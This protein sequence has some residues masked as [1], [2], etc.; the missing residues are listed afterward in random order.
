MGTAVLKKNFFFNFGECH[1]VHCVIIF[2]QCCFKNLALVLQTAVPYPMMCSLTVF[3]PPPVVGTSCGAPPAWPAGT[4]LRL[5][6]CRHEWCSWVTGHIVFH[7]TKHSQPE[8]TVC[9][10][11]YTRLCEGLR[12][13]FV[14]PHPCWALSSP[15]I[16]AHPLE[17]SDVWCFSAP[18]LM[19]VCF[20]G[21]VSF[22]CPFM[23]LAHFGARVAVLLLLCRCSPYPLV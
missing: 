6:G 1:C 23:S 14:P 15:L 16:F 5:P 11:A 19:C 7:L 13:P 4:W 20:W 12:C 8:S 21:L 17:V 9:H 10:L 22:H 3:C 2:T 18:F